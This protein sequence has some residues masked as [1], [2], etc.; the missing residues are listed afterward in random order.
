M[1][2]AREYTWKSIP[3]YRETSEYASEHGEREQY[4]SSR[5]ANKACKAWI[6]EKLSEAMTPADIL[7]QAAE[8]FGKARVKHILAITVQQR[9]YGIAFNAEAVEWGAAQKVI[10]DKSPLGNDRNM[11]LALENAE[12]ERIRDIVQVAIGDQGKKEEKPKEP[13]TKE[14]KEQKNEKIEDEPKK[15]TKETPKK[16]AKT[17]IRD[18]MITRMIGN[19]TSLQQERRKKGETLRAMRLRKGMTQGELAKEAGKSIMTISKYENGQGKILPD[20][21]ERL[22]KILDCEPG[23][24]RE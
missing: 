7:Q 5:K 12:P 16:P 15:E 19:S 20:L 21:A 3:V 24:L 10:P 6:E 17:L 9:K 8:E 1:S 14:I 13:D 11:W 23:T 18:P 2:E 22:E 4:D